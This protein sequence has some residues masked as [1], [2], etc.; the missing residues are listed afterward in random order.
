MSAE[1]CTR[2][3]KPIQVDEHGDRRC[4]NGHALPDSTKLLDALTRLVP[5]MVEIREAIEAQGLELRSLREEVEALRV[6]PSVEPEGEWV[7]LATM[8]RKLRRSE[9]WL[10]RN[11]R[12]LGGRQAKHRGRW[13]FNPALTMAKFGQADE[14]GPARL[15]VRSRPRP[16]P[17]RAPLL[18]VK[19]EAA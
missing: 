3:A 4:Q 15:P 6:E 2:C 13:L 7:N 18:P 5:V 12:A 11:A 17:D 8:A 9:D 16:V 10:R 1:Y 19:G 14:S